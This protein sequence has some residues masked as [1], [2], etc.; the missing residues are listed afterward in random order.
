MLVWLEGKM[1]L[2]EGL[3]G[4]FLCGLK[5]RPLPW[6]VLHWEKVPEKSLSPF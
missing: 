5:D 6:D 3:E 1:S 4:G 2:V